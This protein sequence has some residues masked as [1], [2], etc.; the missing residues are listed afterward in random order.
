MKSIKDQMAEALVKAYANK[1]AIVQQVRDLLKE[2][3][4]DENGRFAGGGGSSSGGDSKSEGDIRI[5]GASYT[6]TERS[7][8][9][10]EQAGTAADSGKAE[11]HH[12]ASVLHADA[13]GTHAAEATAHMAA[14]RV[15][16]ARASARTAV[17]QAAAAN[18]QAILARSKGYD[19][20]KVTEGYV[21]SAK[22]SASTAI[23]ATGESSKYYNAP[24]YK[25]DSLGY[26]P[27]GN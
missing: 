17:G 7:K 2:Q 10:Q 24:S 5:S 26:R 3:E 13:A 20:S 6:G 23:R 14:G 15:D 4:R 9:A 19:T 25:P 21:Q 11:D 22:D 18:D 8:Q 1:D 16:E 12:L 27:R